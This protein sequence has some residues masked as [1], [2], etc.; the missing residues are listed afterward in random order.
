MGEPIKVFLY[1]RTFSYSVRQP[2]TT[3]PSSRC[4]LTLSSLPLIVFAPEIIMVVLPAVVIGILRGM[5]VFLLASL[6]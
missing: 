5:V 3:S 4:V 2:S 6:L 1:V